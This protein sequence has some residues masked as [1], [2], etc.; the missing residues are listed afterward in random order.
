MTAVASPTSFQSG[1]S[2]NAWTNGNS[3]QINLNGMFVPPRKSVERSNSSS[4]LSSNSSSSTTTTTIQQPPQQTNGIQQQP[5]QQTQQQLDSTAATRRRPGRGVWPSSKAEPV[6]GV[7]NARSHSVPAS[8]GPS[9]ASAIS[10]LHSNPSVPNQQHMVSSKQQPNGLSRGHVLQDAPPVLYLLPMNGTFER[11]TIT[12]PL[13]PD[14]LRI[15]RQTNARTTP[16][17][18]NGYF[19]SKVLSRQHAEIWADREG[20]IWIR[21]VKSSNG[22]FVNGKRLSQENRDSEPH[23]LREQDVLELGIDIVSEDQKTVVHHKVAARVEQAG[24]YGVGANPPD[25][26]F[27]ELEQ[28]PLGGHITQLGQ[29]FRSRTTSQGSLA[30]GGRFGNGGGNVPAYHS[31]WLQPVTMEQIVKRLNTELRQARLQSQDLHHTGNFVEAILS[32]EKPAPLPQSQKIASPTKSSEAKARF[33]EPPAPPP[34]QPLPEKPDGGVMSKLA[35]LPALQP[36]LKRSETERPRIPTEN[37]GE[38]PKTDQ[39]N[40]VVSLVE[41]LS[42]AQKEISSQGERLKN[43]EDALRHEREARSLAEEK[44]RIRQP[45]SSG[46]EFLRSEKT[47][48]NDE[49]AEH[50]D[51]HDVGLPERFKHKF[52]LMRAEMDSMRQQVE[53]YRQRAETAEQESRDD[54]ETLAEMVAR[55]RTRD[56]AAEK[57]RI[58]RKQKRA[59]QQRNRE[60]KA[61]EGGETTTANHDGND[62]ELDE[63]LHRADDQLNGHVQAVLSRQKTLRPEEP[64]RSPLDRGGGPW[65][66]KSL[67]QMSGSEL[68]EI[69]KTVE[70]A[71]AAMAGVEKNSSGK[72]VIRR[73]LA[74]ERLIQSAPYAS[75]IGVM[76]VGVSIM[77]YLNGWSRGPRSE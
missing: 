40:N 4:S 3:T 31:K 69:A 41:A 61:S 10:A 21:D 36:L 25:L 72:M 34:S 43:M 57:R 46:P 16:T 19:D 42:T 55:I 49:P 20:K 6:S 56:E 17:P 11:K 13:V 1:L 54:R 29:G 22:T 45:D 59:E 24:I 28:P 8:S 71:S 52:D 32:N 63:E 58:A 65:S 9:A 50:R 48:A 2:R 38:S 37:H 64:L 67:E 18:L 14:I 15:G 75:M 51:D 77:A 39:G 44:A 23:P 47:V 68:R 12:V 33:N 35:E 53:K 27:A 62:D 60:K 5:Q 7:S 70:A 73:G 26:S 74:Q 30:S 66:L 76:V